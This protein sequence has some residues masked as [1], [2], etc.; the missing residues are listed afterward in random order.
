MLRVATGLIATL[1]VL[2]VGGMSPA[3]AH[4]PS[5]E[6]LVIAPLPGPE[7]L[8]RFEVLQATGGQASTE[9]HW[10]FALAVVFAVATLARGRARRLVAIGL[11]VVLVVF[12]V[13]SAKHSV[14]HAPT[15][16]PAACPTAL[17]AAHLNGAT[18]DTLTL[19]APIV[20]IGAR[21]DTLDP[22]VSSLRSLDPKYGRA[23]PSA[24]V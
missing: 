20:L 15:D 24:L 1:A 9:V 6:S 7:V 22:R 2:L 4:Q 14:H 10:L 19:E 21:L 11:V 17:V 8:E 23:P 13:E 5:V 3:G 12:A 16:Q 18:V